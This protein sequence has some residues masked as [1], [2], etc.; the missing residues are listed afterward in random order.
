MYQVLVNQGLIADSSNELIS[1]ANGFNDF[2]TKY[3]E[4]GKNLLIYRIT[5]NDRKEKGEAR[6]AP[7]FVPYNTKFAVRLSVVGTTK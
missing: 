2:M 3:E 4:K 7:V 1:L 6:A 5:D